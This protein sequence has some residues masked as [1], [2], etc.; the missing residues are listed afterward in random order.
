MI[1]KLLCGTVALGG[2]LFAATTAFAQ[3]ASDAASSASSA[4]A[5][6]AATAAASPAAA[7]ALVNLAKLSATAQAAAQALGRRVLVDDLTLRARAPPPSSP[8]PQIAQSP[9]TVSPEATTVREHRC[10]H[11]LSRAGKKIAPGPADQCAPAGPAYAHVV[12]QVSAP[13]RPPPCCPLLRSRGQSSPR[14]TYRRHWR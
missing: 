2:S 1:R 5:T 6:A 13:S 14:K 10:G 4:V 11:G 12:S 7:P 3:A 8:P 9:I